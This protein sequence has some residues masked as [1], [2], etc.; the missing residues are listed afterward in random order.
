[1]KTDEKMSTA[2]FC[3]TSGT[4][5]ILVLEVRKDVNFFRSLE[6]HG[7][8]KVARFEPIPDP[9]TKTYHKSHVQQSLQKV[10]TVGNRVTRHARFA[11]SLKHNRDTTT[12]QLKKKRENNN[13]ACDNTPY[14]RFK[15]AIFA[16]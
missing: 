10:A 1:M 5:L 8:C 4:E 13:F 11:R 2:V 6:H 9:R 15:N 3:K 14:P 16:I 7:R 12:A